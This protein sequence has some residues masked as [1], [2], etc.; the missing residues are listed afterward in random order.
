MTRDY[1]YDVALSFAGEDRE[2]AE[3]LAN[4]LRENGYKVF[5]DK[6]E[7]GQLWGKNLYEH[8]LSVYRDQCRFCVIFMSEHYKQKPWTN[9]EL[10][11]ALERTAHE[12]S[13][14]V[15]PI[16]VDSADISGMLASAASL[17]LRETAV[18]DIFKALEEKI[19]KDRELTAPS[20]ESAPGMEPRT[21]D[22]IIIDRIEETIEYQFDTD[23]PTIAVIARPTYL[24]RPLISLDE[25]YQFAQKSHSR[26]DGSGFANWF[27]ASKVV[28]GLSA[29]SLP[30]KRLLKYWELNRYGV[31]YARRAFRHCHKELYEEWPLMYDGKQRFLLHSSD[32][33]YQ[34]GGLLHY[35]SAFYNACGYTGNIDAEI[36]LKNVGGEFLFYNREIDL[37]REI[38]PRHYLLDHPYECL[39]PKV[40][41]ATRRPAAYLSDA[42]KMVALI[43]ELTAPLLWAFNVDIDGE[44]SRA[45]KIRSILAN[46]QLLPGVDANKRVVETAGAVQK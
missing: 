35:A 36:Q 11:S 1:E 17:D 37:R 4:L 46:E 38:I 28:D 19:V 39:H 18:A 45:S 27:C 6:F 22:Q 24:A 33:P 34:L 5:Y 25:L 3:A 26:V 7:A 9:L 16:K 31:V 44:E 42:N 20:P 13:E 43:D 2:Y 21:D 40:S 29:S 30:G 15:L 12:K 23:L 32:I 8:F 10:R 41:Q 14:R